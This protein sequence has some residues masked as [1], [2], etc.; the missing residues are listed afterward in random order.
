MMNKPIVKEMRV[1]PPT[2]QQAKKIPILL[3]K[4]FSEQ[5]ADFWEF[6]HETGL[7]PEEI[8]NLN[9]SQFIEQQSHSEPNCFFYE[10][11]S[12]KA[13]TTVC[14]SKQLSPV[15]TKIIRK[16]RNKHPDSKFLF[17]SYRSRNV[18]NKEPQPLSRQAISRAFKEVGEMLG[19]KLTPMSMRQLALKRISVI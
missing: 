6:G 10:I 4:H 14:D 7:R 3:R 19:M 16:I 9:F 17:Q 11:E 18:S 15:A 2:S 12:R 8:R 5:L 13:R 1:E